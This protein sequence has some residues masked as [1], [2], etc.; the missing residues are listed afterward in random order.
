MS[1]QQ[2]R[3]NREGLLYRPCVGIALFNA[4]GKVL[5]VSALTHR[6]LGKCLKVA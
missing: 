1:A 4:E 6:G 5:S 2:K 3:I